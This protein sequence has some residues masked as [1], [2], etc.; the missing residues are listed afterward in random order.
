MKIS[1][2]YN[3]RYTG[4]QVKFNYMTLNLWQNFTYK[5]IIKEELIWLKILE[6]WVWPN[7]IIYTLRNN[8]PKNKFYWLDLS[9][10]V[11]NKI[12]ELGITWIK[13]SLWEEKIPFD[14]NFFDIII[15]NEVIEHIF[16][17][18]NALS[19]IYRI[20]KKWWKFFISTH[21]SFNFVMRI[22]Y[23]F[24]VIPTPSLDVSSDSMWEHIRLFNYSILL[25]ILL[26][27]WFSK[28]DLINKSWFKFW[29][30]EF[31][32]YFM[33]KTL[34]RHFSIICKKKD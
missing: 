13:A 19:E 10:N 11:L 23:L 14:D 31:Y 8:Y 20:L 30:F 27:A 6:I 26:K 24:W 4:K 3:K 22:K 34:A 5:E 29:I 9:E 15:F 12:E 18:Q 16:D 33:T 21:N 7:W 25:K 32:T 2:F 17:C 1:E 28:N